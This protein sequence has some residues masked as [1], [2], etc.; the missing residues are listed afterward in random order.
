V[1]VLVRPRASRDEVMGWV[2]SA[3]RVRVTAPPAGGAANEAVRDLL[4][5][6]LGC[7]RSAIEIVRGAGART[8]LV[9]VAG[10]SPGELR[11]RLSSSWGGASA[12]SPRPPT[13]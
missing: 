10:L 2:G 12:A 4:A 8:K 6:T 9:R 1:T 13:G 5:R 3:L 11:A 7:A